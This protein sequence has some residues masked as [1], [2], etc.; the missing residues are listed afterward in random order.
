MSDNPKQP[1]I[2]GV[3]GAGTN[4]VSGIQKDIP[5]GVCVVKANTDV[6]SLNRPDNAGG[7]KIQLGVHCLQ[8]HGAGAN[9]EAGSQAAKESLDEFSSLILDAS[10]VV[11]IAGMGGGTG[12]GATPVFVK[13][14]VERQ[15]PTAVIAI[16]PFDF[17][18]QRRFGKALTSIRSFDDPSIILIRLSNQL[19]LSKHRPEDLNMLECFKLMDEM[20]G[21]MALSLINQLKKQFCER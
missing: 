9:P 16:L 7:R 14:A 13:V 20:A 2:I 5:S 8:G 12:A 19:P 3:G 4:I 10:F 17:E 1:F 18:G 15:I 21:Q 6:E 11:F